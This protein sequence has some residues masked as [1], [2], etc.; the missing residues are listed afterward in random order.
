MSMGGEGGKQ[1]DN[2]AYEVYELKG[3]YNE[4]NTLTFMRYSASV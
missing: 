1:G 3:L 4:I 2:Y